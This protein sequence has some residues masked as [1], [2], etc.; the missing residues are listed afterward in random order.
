M[1]EMHSDLADP[2]VIHCP[3]LVA[4]LEGSRARADREQARARAVRAAALASRVPERT[5]RRWRARWRRPAQF[6][7]QVLAVCGEA[8]WSAIA[9]ELAPEA[10]CAD[11]VGAYAATRPTPPGQLH[12]GVAALVYRL[13]PKVRLM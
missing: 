4:E 6:L 11:L 1:C 7:A 13:Q 10:T 8:A 5:R 12:A 2:T 3:A 9:G